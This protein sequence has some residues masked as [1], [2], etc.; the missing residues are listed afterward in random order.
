MS[1]VGAGEGVG[2][3]EPVLEVLQ[4]GD[5]NLDGGSGLGV[6]GAIGDEGH[7]L[8]T[9]VSAAARLLLRVVAE[10]GE[11]VS[12]VADAYAVVEEVGHRDFIGEKELALGEVAG[13]VKRDDAAKGIGG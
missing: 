13:A 11:V 10:D 6:V 5:W 8:G 12:A 4:F 2:G 1:D 9:D 7:V 3:D